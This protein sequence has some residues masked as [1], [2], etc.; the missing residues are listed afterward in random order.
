LKLYLIR[1]RFR[2]FCGLGNGLLR[3]TSGHNRG[4]SS[5][6]RGNRRD[7]SADG[8]YPVGY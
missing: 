3:K 5:D 7:D 2:S 8:A 4:A 6:D 1:S